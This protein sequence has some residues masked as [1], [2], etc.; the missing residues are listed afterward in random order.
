MSTWGGR[1]AILAAAVAIVACAT[2]EKPT[3]SPER[4]E[5]LGVTP[6]GLSLQVTLKAENPNDFG[7]SA[8]SVKAR[9]VLDGT[10]DLGEV[11]VASKVALPKKGSA[12]I[13][14]PMQVPWTNL[15]AIGMLAA[16]KPVIPFTMTGTANV[17]GEGLNVDLPFTL[18]GS[19]TR[20]QLL[21]ATAT[22]LP[23]LPF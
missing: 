6:Q 18:A 21:Q 19:L 11:T 17:G 16:S 23:G 8:R 2:P 14:V 7:L 4:V 15:V 1:T 13:V 20:E 9:V 12:S 22:G 10:T 3:L 5:V